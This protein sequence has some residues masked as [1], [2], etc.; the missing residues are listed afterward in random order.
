MQALSQQEKGDN[1]INALV[2]KSWEDSSFKQRLIESPVQTIRDFSDAPF[3]VPAGTDVVVTDQSNPSTIYINIPAQPDLDSLELTDE[4]LEAVAGGIS[5]A[6]PVYC[7]III[8]GIAV[9]KCLN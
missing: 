2:S 3:N 8:A 6:I 9:G 5:P 1:L 4:Q 7:A